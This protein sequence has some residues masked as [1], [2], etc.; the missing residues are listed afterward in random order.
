MKE[1]QLMKKIQQE[2]IEK[3]KHR[4]PIAQGLSWTTDEPQV[5]SESK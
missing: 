5:S 4:I 2:M 1:Q 3:E